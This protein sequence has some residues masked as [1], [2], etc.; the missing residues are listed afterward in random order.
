MPHMSWIF[1]SPHR[2]QN[3]IH[4]YYTILANV[5]KY[6]ISSSI[7]TNFDKCFSQSL[8][9][10]LE[11]LLYTVWILNIWVNFGRSVDWYNFSQFFIANLRDGVCFLSSLYLQRNKLFTGWRQ[12]NQYVTVRPQWG[13]LMLLLVCWLRSPRGFRQLLGIGGTG[14]KNIKNSFS[15]LLFLL[16]KWLKG[17]GAG[18]GRR[19]WHSGSAGVSP[20]WLG[21]DSC[22]MQ[23]SD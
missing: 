3:Y 2:K 4:I 6:Y 17:R 21:L 12:L 1:S 22:S 10:S 9:N 15:L 8:Y 20:L 18:G 14:I 19:S 16:Y 11:G 5:F 7:L 13:C 23:L